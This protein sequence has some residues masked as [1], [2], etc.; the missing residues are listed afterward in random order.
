[1]ATLMLP[2][3]VVVAELLCLLIAPCS[4]RV[5]REEVNPSIH[6]TNPRGAAAAARWVGMHHILCCDTDFYLCADCWKCLVKG[7]MTNCAVGT[8]HLKQLNVCV[9]SNYTNSSKQHTTVA[10]ARS[11]RLHLQIL[12]C[13]LEAVSLFWLMRALKVTQRQKCYL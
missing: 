4:Q 11:P 9:S 12:M 3:C 10:V 6:P 7:H 1:M 13:F 5:W 8:T 2:L